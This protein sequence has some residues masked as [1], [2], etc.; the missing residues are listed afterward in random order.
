MP[1]LTYQTIYQVKK[2]KM[3]VTLNATL[4]TISQRCD[5]YTNH[6]YAQHMYVQ[7]LDMEHAELLGKR[8]FDYGYD[9]YDGMLG[10]YDGIP[11]DITHD[12]DILD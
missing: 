5:F 1:P 3:K 10:S 6:I 9:L 4:F 11:D 7:A 8:I 12:D 2:N